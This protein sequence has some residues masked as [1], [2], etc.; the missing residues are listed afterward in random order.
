MINVALNIVIDKLDRE[1]IYTK[2]Q[3]LNVINNGVFKEHNY[4]MKRHHLIINFTMGEWSKEHKRYC[5]FSKSKDLEGICLRGLYNGYHKISMLTKPKIHQTAFAHELLHY[6]KQYI[7]GSSD[8]EH[9]SKEF[10]DRLVGFKVKGEV[11]IL[12]EELKK[13]GL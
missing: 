6:F 13:A 12:N 11:G 8:K 4:T 5:I 9:K 10:W 7:D 3:M 1:G 2:Q